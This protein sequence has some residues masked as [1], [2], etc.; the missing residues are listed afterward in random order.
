MNISRIRAL[1]GPNLWSRRTA[2]EAIVTCEET[3]RC[4]DDLPG[5]EARLRARFPEIGPLHP[6]GHREADSIAHV[7]AAA[8][9]A[10]QAQA[11]C[12]VSFVQATPT[13]D[14]GV[15]QVVV[16][17]T[18]EPVGRFALELADALCR[19]AIDDTGFDLAD[20]LAR[21]REMDEEVRM[22]PST[23]SIVQAAVA[24]GIPYRRLTD[25]SLVQFGWGSRQR[26]IQAA[27]LDATSAIAE[28]IAQDKDLT[29]QLLDAVGVPVPL[30]RAVTSLDEAVAA[31]EALGGAVVVKPRD[32]NQGKGVSVNV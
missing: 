17:Y 7:L 27:E 13:T 5:F 6:L 31:F 30:G 11:G 8:T 18:E 19:S 23:N 16:E 26:H 29:K 14:P 2:I 28:Q 3:E 10:L 22:G 1:R 4:I 15:Y 20:A 9:L 32:G 21:L 24:R 12:A 25:G